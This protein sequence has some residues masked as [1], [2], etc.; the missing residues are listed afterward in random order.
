MEIERILKIEAQLLDK[1][2]DGYDSV[3]TD[4]GATNK[5]KLLLSRS[6]PFLLAQGK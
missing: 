6:I 1:D 2:K 4:R 5:A 3:V